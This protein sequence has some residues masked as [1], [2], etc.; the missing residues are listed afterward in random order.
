MT[1][2]LS[3]LEVSMYNY[4]NMSFHCGILKSLKVLVR[5]CQVW[6]KR[7]YY[8]WTNTEAIRTRLLHPI[9]CSKKYDEK[10]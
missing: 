4:L 10:L 8:I 9:M 3:D 6:S 5:K 7:L 2:I 1:E